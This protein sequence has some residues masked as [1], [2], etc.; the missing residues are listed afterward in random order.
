VTVKIGGLTTYVSD[1]ILSD[2]L[3]SLAASDA[4]LLAMDANATVDERDRFQRS[5]L[6]PNCTLRLCFEAGLKDSYRQLHPSLGF[7]FHRPDPSGLPLLFSHLDYIFYHGRALTLMSSVADFPP[8][9]VRSDHFALTSMFRV[10]LRAPL[11]CLPTLL[12]GVVQVHRASGRKKA[13]FADAVDQQK[14]L[15]PAAADGAK[16][17]HRGL[18]SDTQKMR[19]LLNTSCFITLFDPLPSHVVLA[20]DRP[21]SAGYF[22]LLCELF[23]FPVTRPLASLCTRYFSS[24]SI[25]LCLKMQLCAQMLP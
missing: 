5:A 20:S 24:F 10:S 19:F 9:G 11:S 17:N 7:T 6:A 25:F 18:I 16:D 8:A 13:Q 15:E 1:S 23:I 12:R 4:L 22:L 21:L 14:V 2:I 3:S